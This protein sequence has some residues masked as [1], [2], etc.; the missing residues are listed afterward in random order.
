MKKT[1]GFT[2]IE[3]LVVISIL[4]LLSSIVL[5]SVQRAK[6]KAYYTRGE[7]EARE[8]GTAMELYALDNNERYP[9]D[10]GRSLPPGLEK[11]LSTSPDWPKAPWPGSVY[12][13]DYWSSSDPGCAGS[14]T[15]PPN[16]EPVYQLSIRFCDPSC[17]CN[18]P[19][20]SWA[21]GFDCQSS[22]Y[23]C[24]SGLCRAH[25]NAEYDH[26]GCC[27][28]GKCPIDQPRCAF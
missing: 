19:Y 8:I 9:C 12:D 23:W 2:L 15:Y 4:G 28:G 27:F 24:V 25:G 5:V 14:L 16:S 22:I 11:Y 20:E 10:I 3:L 6:R 26:P 13:W 18:Y 21:S 1:R 17:V 7:L